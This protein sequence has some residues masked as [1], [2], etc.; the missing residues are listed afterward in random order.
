M[1]TQFL[2]R[3]ITAIHGVTRRWETRIKEMSP[4]P[5]GAAVWLSGREEK[6]TSLKRKTVFPLE[7]TTGN[8]GKMKG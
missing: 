7:V 6:Q 2:C 8:G 4:R 1:K 5:L 3:E